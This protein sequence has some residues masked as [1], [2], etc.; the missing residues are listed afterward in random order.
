MKR[1][2]ISTMLYVASMLPQ[3]VEAF[4]EDPYITPAHPAPDRPIFVNV[5][6]GG[7][8]GSLD[9][10]DGAELQVIAPG[11]LRLITNGIA[12]DPGHPFCKGRLSPTVSV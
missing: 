12:L 3:T 1:W 10:V 9:A 4:V 2:L 5:Y 6:M 8:H 7:C 11:Q